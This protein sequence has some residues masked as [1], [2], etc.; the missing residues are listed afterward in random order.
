M[1][2]ARAA[3]R[4]SVTEAELDEEIAYHLDRDVRRLTAG[5]MSPADAHLAARR[6][7]GN[8]G[9]LKEQVRDSWG[10]RW[11]EHLR[12]D[13]QFALRGFRRAPAFVATVVLTIALA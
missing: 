9:Y 11:A 7:F 2:R 3:F 13:V 10:L 1:V 6:A 4:R 8:S 12:Q 5:G